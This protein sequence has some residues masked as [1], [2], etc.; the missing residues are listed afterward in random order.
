MLGKVSL[1]SLALRGF[2]AAPHSRD[3]T[4]PYIGSSWFASARQS[5]LRKCGTQEDLEHLRQTF[6]ESFDFVLRQLDHLIQDLVNEV[7]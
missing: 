3:L 1:N 5:R 4:A 7:L 2:G 6:F